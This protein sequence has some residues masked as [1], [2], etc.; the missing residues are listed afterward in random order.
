MALK[1]GKESGSRP[2]RFY[3]REEPGTHCIGGCV[4]RRA[5]LDRCRKS[6]P[7]PGIDPRTVQPV[8]SRY[9]Y[10]V[11]QP[12]QTPSRNLFLRH[13]TIPQS[14]Q[15]NLKLHLFHQQR[16]NIQK[17][18]TKHIFCETNTLT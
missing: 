3:P 10:C 18:L 8:A 17:P 5:G 1:G 12:T 4:G 2:G 15:I 6:R 11:T 16:L 14:L 9:T 7:P 13:C